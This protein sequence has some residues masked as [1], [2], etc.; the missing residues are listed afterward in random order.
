MVLAHTSVKRFVA[1][2]LP[3]SFVWVFIACVMLCTECTVER[4]ASSRSFQDGTVSLNQEREGCPINATQPSI[5]PDRTDTFSVSGMQLAPAV[6]SA[7]LTQPTLFKDEN[8]ATLI[9]TSDPP[10]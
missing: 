9:A 7:Q 5:L 6:L 10:F 3:L 1:M 2:V 8:S 4:Q